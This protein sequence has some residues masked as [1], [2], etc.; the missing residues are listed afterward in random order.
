MKTLPFVL[1]ALAM[2]ALAACSGTTVMSAASTAGIW[3]TRPGAPPP[4]DTADQI[5]EHESW[6]Y[7]TMGY[8]E[9]YAHPQDVDPNRLINVDPQNRYPLTARDY[10]ELV[11]A[12]R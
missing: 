7:E 5:A 8:A 6:C 9:C 10:Q 11:Y 2:L 12:D 4:A 1:L 3:Y